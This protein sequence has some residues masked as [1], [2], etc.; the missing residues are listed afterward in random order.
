MKSKKSGRRGLWLSCMVFVVLSH[1]ACGYHAPYSIRDASSTIYRRHAA[2]I[3]ARTR[4]GNQF[5]PMVKAKTA[6]DAVENVR[7][8]LSK[9]GLLQTTAF[10]ALVSAPLGMLL[11]NQHGLF[12]VLEYAPWGLPINIYWSGKVVLKT[13]AWVPILFGFAGWIMSIIVLVLD[14][15]FDTSAAKRNPTWP[16][17]LYGI[18]MFSG[19][20]YLSGLLDHVQVHNVVIHVV[21]AAIAAF[22]FHVFDGTKAGLVLAVATAVSGPIAEIL[23]INLPKLYIYT[24]AD[25]LGICSWIPWVYFLGAPAVGN[26]ARKLLVTQEAKS[27]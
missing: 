20:Y 13:A 12:G 26:L 10:M 24:H 23:L 11:D 19:Q 7:A 21:L 4:T 22:G 27:P 6:D 18:S 8:L 15:F 3:I 17:V 16:M 9:K 5:P 1:V 14:E 25:V 2:G